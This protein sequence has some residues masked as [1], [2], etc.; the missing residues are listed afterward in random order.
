MSQ[1][2]RW[3][4][5]DTY[6]HDRQV[7][8]TSPPLPPPPPPPLTAGFSSTVFIRPPGERWRPDENTFDW[9]MTLCQ[10]LMETGTLGNRVG[11]DVSNQSSRGRKNNRRAFLFWSPL[12]QQW[13]A[14]VPHCWERCVPLNWKLHVSD[15][16]AE[17]N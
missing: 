16:R 5:C 14:W 7:S 4:L 6:C 12:H 13:S 11:N 1:V 9:K 8:S 3:Y 2:L 10:E 17:N 15:L